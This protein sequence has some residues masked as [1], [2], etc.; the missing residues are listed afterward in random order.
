MTFILGKGHFGIVASLKKTIN[1]NNFIV[2]ENLIL[3][4]LDV[5]LREGIIIHI[6]NN[7][8]KALKMTNFDYFFSDIFIAC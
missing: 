7:D 4:T 1:V 3:G 8:G 2:S 6:F 5:N